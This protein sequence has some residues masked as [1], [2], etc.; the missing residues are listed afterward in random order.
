MSMWPLV[1]RDG[2]FG[3]EGTVFND[4]AVTVVGRF[5]GP[6]GWSVLKRMEVP[7]ASQVE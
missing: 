3:T 1:T 4:L 5:C 6:V 7:R 2:P